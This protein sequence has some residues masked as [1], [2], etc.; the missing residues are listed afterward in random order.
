M[1]TRQD[2]G[3]IPLKCTVHLFGQNGLI[4]KFTDDNKTL[5][6]RK[7]PGMFIIGC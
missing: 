6:D 3:N 5:K 4:R 2:D 7:T 1:S